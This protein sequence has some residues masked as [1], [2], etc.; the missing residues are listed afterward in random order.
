MTILINR[1]NMNTLS[2]PL[3]MF[4]LYSLVFCCGSDGFDESP[5]T[6]ELYSTPN[7]C[8]W[9]PL[10]DLVACLP[11]SM[12]TVSGTLSADRRV[13]TFPNN[14]RI[15]FDPPAQV[16]QTGSWSFGIT[17]YDRAGG[18]CARIRTQRVGSTVGAPSSL[19]L[20]ITRTGLEPVTVRSATSLS[21]TCGTQRYTAPWSE[22]LQC[23]RYAMARG[24]PEIQCHPYAGQQNISCYI[25]ENGLRTTQLFNC[26]PGQ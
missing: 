22:I 16:R 14:T 21:L 15:E 17:V 8:W 10:D 18:L 4:C 25:Q 2:A 11:T 24:Y 9:R 19:S 7:S 12:S 13:C 5:L 23:N 1:P 6:C 20:D 26:L 3:R